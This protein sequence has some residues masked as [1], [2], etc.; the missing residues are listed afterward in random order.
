MWVGVIALLLNSFTRMVNCSIRGLPPENAAA[1]LLKKGRR[2]LPSVHNGA[3]WRKAPLQPIAFIPP[4]LV[5]QKVDGRQFNQIA[6][7][8]WRD[9]PNSRANPLS[10]RAFFAR[11]IIY[12]IR[13]VKRTKCAQIYILTS[14]SILRFSIDAYRKYPRY[15]M[16][17]KN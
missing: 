17:T 7:A 2:R 15:C 5:S 12:A 13:S 6:S 10:L 3:F 11:R 4:P 14:N 9:A 1:R 16:L 8:P